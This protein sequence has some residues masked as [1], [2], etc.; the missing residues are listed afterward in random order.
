MKKSTRRNFLSTAAVLGATGAISA[1]PV[2]SGS[3]IEPVVHHV[4]FWLKN[5]DSKEDRAKLIEG[6]RGLSKI[7]NVKEIHVGV[8]ADTEKR[9]VVDTSWQ[10]SELIF[11]HDLAG[12]AT[13]QSHQ[14]HLDFVKNYGPLWQ[15]VVVYDMILV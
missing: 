14:V 2:R 7:E 4:F 13:Y 3:A 12:Q 8:L 11:F 1:M 5:P 9:T 6:V 15:K 10:V